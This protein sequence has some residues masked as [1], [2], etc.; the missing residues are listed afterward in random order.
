MLQLGDCEGVTLEFGGE[1]IAG[2]LRP[3]V[4]DFNR[5][6]RLTH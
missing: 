6:T 3:L 1:E 4:F 2:E 5:Q